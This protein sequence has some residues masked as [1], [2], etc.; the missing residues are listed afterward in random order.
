MVVLTYGCVAT[1]F[2]PFVIRIER[3]LLIHIETL[4]YVLL[5]RHDTVDGKAVPEEQVLHWEEET[6]AQLDL[7]R[8]RS[9]PRLRKRTTAGF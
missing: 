8:P 7:G 9:T 3:G 5:Q 2:T 4:L 1:L 6:G